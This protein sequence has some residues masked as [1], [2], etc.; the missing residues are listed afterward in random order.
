M[1]IR[2]IALALLTAVLHGQEQAVDR[3]LQSVERQRAAIERHRKALQTRYPSFFAARDEVPVAAGP[4]LGD[5]PPLTASDVKPIVAREAERQ[6]VSNALVHA[7][8][9][10]ESAYSPCAVSP[11]GAQGLMQ[12]MPAT[13]AGLGVENPFDPEQNISGGTQFLRQ[14]LDRYGGDVAKALAAYNAGPGRVDAANG[15][16]PIPETETYVRKI[17]NRITPP[18]FVR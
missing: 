6:K 2:P 5:C 4:V 18:E 1:L 12:L 14:M 15:I 13:A 10:A 16:P 11:V 8:I 9:E 7:V 3:Q 17:I